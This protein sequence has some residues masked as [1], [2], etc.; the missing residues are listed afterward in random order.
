VPRGV[1]FEF[2]VPHHIFLLKRNQNKKR[3]TKKRKKKRKEKKKKKKSR[4]GWSFV[5]PRAK[6]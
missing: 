5:W 1:L 4:T 6:P 2:F 3:K